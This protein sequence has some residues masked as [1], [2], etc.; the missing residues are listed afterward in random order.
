MLAIASWKTTVITIMHLCPIACLHVYQMACDVSYKEVNPVYHTLCPSRLLH[1][2]LNYDQLTVDTQISYHIHIG[3][4]V[5][6][7]TLHTC[8]STP[9]NKG[10]QY[11]TSKGALFTYY[12]ICQKLD[13]FLKFTIRVW[14]MT[15]DKS[16][17]YIKMFSTRLVTKYS[18]HSPA[19]NTASKGV[20]EWLQKRVAVVI[21]IHSRH[22]EFLST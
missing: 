14:Y 1:L 21:W 16:N 15:T 6:N 19:N 11:I 17:L 22:A 10:Q 2:Q 8:I 18:L 9:L 5:T 13:H 12:A 20:L 3:T 7:L 4:N